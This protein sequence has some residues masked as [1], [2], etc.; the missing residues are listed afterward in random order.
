[1]LQVSRVFREKDQ[2]MTEKLCRRE[3]RRL[4]VKVR[5]SFLAHVAPIICGTSRVS[6]LTDKQEQPLRWRLVQVGAECAHATD[7]GTDEIDVE[8]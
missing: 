2:G 1:M 3:D 7:D 5:V 4:L 6:I 8:Y